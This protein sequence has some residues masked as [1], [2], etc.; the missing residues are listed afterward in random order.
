MNDN[1]VKDRLL[2]AFEWLEE[3]KG[4]IPSDENYKNADIIQKFINCYQAEINRQKEEINRLQKE[5]DDK[6]R[7]YTKEYILRKEMKED[8]NRLTVELQAMR[9]AASSYKMHYE[10]AKAEIERLKEENI[11]FS[12]KRANI[13]EIISAYDRGKT[14]AIK[15]FAER[16][17]LRF[18]GNLYCNGGTVVRAVD[19]IIKEMTQEGGGADG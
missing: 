2:T 15:E 1:D 4:S 10:K 8:I 19:K 3:I 17:K 5:S 11:I 16:L 9:G 14:E 12:Q 7:A 6:E 13:F 18:S